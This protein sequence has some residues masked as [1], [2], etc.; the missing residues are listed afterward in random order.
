MALFGGDTVR[1][2]GAAVLGCTAIGHVEP[3]W[4][5]DR[6]GARAGDA[7][8]VSGTLGEAGLGL[9]MARGDA[10]VEKRLL[11]RYRRP[12]PRLALGRALAGT[13]TAAMDVSD[14]LL[15]DAARLAAASGVAVEIELDC[16]PVVGDPLA[17]VT[18]GDDYELLFTA[19]PGAAIA[20][21]ATA[22]LP[23]ARIGTVVAGSGLRLL[24]G[25]RDVTPASARLGALNRRALAMLCHICH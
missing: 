9:A 25:A 3:G 2:G 4:A 17:A 24:D 23:L 14:G 22:K 16:V 8:W 5:L 6:R 18:A 20:V 1:W 11:N 13:A 10:P 7:L 12:E 21:L 19:P 15:I